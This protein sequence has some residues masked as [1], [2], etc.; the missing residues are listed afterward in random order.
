MEDD[1]GRGR[2]GW[3]EAASPLNMSC[4]GKAEWEDSPP[5]EYYI[6]VPL[7]L[8]GLV[9]PPSLA[10][11]LSPFFSLCTSIQVDLG[12]GLGARS[13]RCEPFLTSHH[14]LLTTLAKSDSTPNPLGMVTSELWAER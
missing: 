10:L 3:G 11:S 1:R 6:S 5:P 9:A 8:P 14:L 2:C 4:L 13:F 7:C 12:E